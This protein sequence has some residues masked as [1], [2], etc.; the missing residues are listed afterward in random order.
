MTKERAL[1]T[2][3]QA[4]SVPYRMENGI[5]TNPK[6]ITNRT[7][8]HPSVKP[9]DI[10]SYLIKLSTR[11]GDTVLDP[12]LGSGSTMIASRNLRRNCIGMERE[13]QYIKIAKGRL[14][15]NAMQKMGNIECVLL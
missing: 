6:A 8:I 12:F 15:W 5:A 4:E 14:Q 7:N 11:E 10:M 13:E 2:N 3:F 1:V 9:I